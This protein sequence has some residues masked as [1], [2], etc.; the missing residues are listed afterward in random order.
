MINKWKNKIKKHFEEVLK[1]KTSSREIALG[2]AIGT[3]IAILPTFGFGIF[4]GLLVIFLFKKVSKIALLGAFVVWNPL[5][6]AL[7]YVPSYYLGDLIVGELPT[8]TFRFEFVSQVY[9]L[10]RR[11]LVGNFVLAVV[12]SVVSYF[13]VLKLVEKYY[14]VRD[15]RVLN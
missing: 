8:R 1:I 9:V 7:L 2:F 6:L 13:V 14:K 15:E 5:V 11:Y 3:L 10:T 12:L 4:I